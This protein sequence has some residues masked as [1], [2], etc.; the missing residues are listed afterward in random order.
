MKRGKSARGYK[1][2]PKQDSNLPEFYRA[3]LLREQPTGPIPVGPRLGPN[4]GERE[5][6]VACH[7]V[8][9]H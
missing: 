8:S 7:S 5:T 6:A 1:S 2:S 9:R 3:G 4:E